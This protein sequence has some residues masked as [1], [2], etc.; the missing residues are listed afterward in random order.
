MCMCESMV[1]SGRGLESRL[2]ACGLGPDD[3]ILIELLAKVRCERLYVAV[4]PAKA[5]SDKAGSE[6]VIQ[7]DILS[8]Q[9]D[10]RI[11]FITKLQLGYA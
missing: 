11:G 8:L 1:P 3:C 6:V 10:G 5:T 7:P 2:T 9:D 4:R